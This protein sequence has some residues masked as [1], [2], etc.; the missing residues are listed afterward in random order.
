M[1]NSAQTGINI[2]W[3]SRVINP[4]VEFKYYDYW[5]IYNPNKVY[6]VEIFEANFDG[7]RKKYKFKLILCLDKHY[8]VASEVLDPIELQQLR[9]YCKCKKCT[10]IFRFLYFNKRCALDPKLNYQ[11]DKYIKICR[12]IR[13]RKIKI[14]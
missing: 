14:S 10:S 3:S 9:P 13:D 11:N 6:N 1:A 2:V 7:K 12:Q 4:D 5:D 8:V